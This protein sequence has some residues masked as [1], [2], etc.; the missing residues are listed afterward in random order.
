MRNLF[1]LIMGIVSIAIMIPIAEVCAAE[2]KEVEAENSSVFQKASD[3]ING[4]YEV[5]VTPLKKIRVFQAVA[6]WIGE[7]KRSDIKPDRKEN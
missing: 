6:D 7:V 1:F 2:N 3:V 5:K 4:K